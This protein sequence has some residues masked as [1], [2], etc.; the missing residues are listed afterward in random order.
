M[1][2]KE[3]EVVPVPTNS[4]K[5]GIVR[6]LVIAVGLFV[7]MIL[8]QFLFQMLAC[9]VVPDILPSCSAISVSDSD[10]LD[11]IEVE[12]ELAPPI[13]LPL[14]PPLVAT[15]E[16][17]STVRFLQLTL[18]VMARDQESIDAVQN[19]MPVIRNN[20]LMLMGGRTLTDL[21]SRE[22]KEALRAEALEEVQR[23]LAKNASIEEPGVEELYF[24]SFVVQ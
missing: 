14:D 12:E 2:A 7:L 17:Q 1:A 16:D 13:Y 21:T 11:D 15:F 20:L 10:E 24:T 8:S 4:S 18:E 19:H 22:G 3:S 23:V 5:G 9:K 6:T